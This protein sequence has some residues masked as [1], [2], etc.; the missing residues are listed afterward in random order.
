[1]DPRAVPA[2]K[3]ALAI[4]AQAWRELEEEDRVLL[5]TRYSTAVINLS[6]RPE[7]GL[8]RRFTKENIRAGKLVSGPRNCGKT[9][10]LLEVIHEDFAGVAVIVC[11]SGTEARIYRN[12]YREMFPN[13]R[14]PRFVSAKNEQA[15]EGLSG[16][17]VDGFERMSRWA[18][19]LLL[20]GPEPVRGI[21]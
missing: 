17:F 7:D 5:G 6:D 20:A 19:E 18:Q 13:D 15:L 9:Q 3:D 12:R 4:I 16:A 14:R 11:A 2:A 10:G 8:S 21:A 1:M